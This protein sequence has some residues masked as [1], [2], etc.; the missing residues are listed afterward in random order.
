MR[1]DRSTSYWIVP[2]PA[3]PMPGRVAACHLGDLLTRL[4]YYQNR[5]LFVALYWRRQT[6]CHVLEPGQMVWISIRASKSRGATLVS[7]SNCSTHH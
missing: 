4:E 6:A 2:S 5:H 3:T 1:T 7:T